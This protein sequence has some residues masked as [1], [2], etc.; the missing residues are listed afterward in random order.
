MRTII[1]GSHAQKKEDHIFWS[2]GRVQI[3]EMNQ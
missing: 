1:F 3:K 2:N